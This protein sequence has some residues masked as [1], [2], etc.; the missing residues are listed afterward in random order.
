MFGSCSS[1][2][3]DDH[4]ER[5]GAVEACGVDGRP[6]IGFSFG[7]SHGAIAVGDFSLDHARAEFA[8]GRIV[9]DVNLAGIVAFT[10]TV[11]SIPNIR[12]SSLT[13]HS[14]KRSRL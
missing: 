2:C 13:R 6:D 5:I 8:L 7:G 9:R 4:R 12:A 3:A 1:Q 10:V 11:T 14:P